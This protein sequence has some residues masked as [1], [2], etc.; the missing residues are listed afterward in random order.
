MSKWRIVTQDN[1]DRPFCVEWNM[2]FWLGGWTPYTQYKTLADARKA[3]KA[4]E[5]DD[6]NPF[7]KEIIE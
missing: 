5:A 6:N 2:G 4:F 7:K 1:P 3:K